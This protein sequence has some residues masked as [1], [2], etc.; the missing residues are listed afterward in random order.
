[1]SRA[2]A[3]AADLRS[4]RTGG[5]GST[6]GQAPDLTV[7]P[8]HEGS[9]VAA[10]PILLAAQLLD[11]VPVV[12]PDA[13]PAD[14]QVLARAA[15]LRRT[16]DRGEPLLVV[17]TSGTSGRPRAVVRT[18]ASWQASWAGFDTL[19]DGACA[20][21]EV[22]WVPGATASTLT[23]FGLWHALATGRPVVASGRWRGGSNA[24]A[25]AGATAVHC[26]PAV[27]ADL[28]DARAAGQLPALRRAIVA[29]AAF[30]AGLRRRAIALG[31][32]PVEYYGAAELSFV[33]ADPDGSGLRAFPGAEVSIRDGLIWVRSP[34]LARGYLDPRDGGPLRR[35]AAGWASVGDR[36]HLSADG[37]LTVRGRGD[38]TASVG[39]HTVILDDVER[40]L[41]AVDGVAEVVCLAVPD[42]RFG[43]R[44]LAAVRPAP[45]TTPSDL[46]G[47]LRAAA[48]AQLQPAARPARYMVREELPRTPGGKVAR[49]LLA[50]ELTSVDRTSHR[51]LPA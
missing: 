45:G 16:G 37:V 30:P 43:Q 18:T 12:T 33:A 13:T 42:P 14:D 46:V 27:L 38:G 24:G 9:P 28:L 40:A 5:G 41:A 21:G 3:I 17:V 35:E 2:E 19:L 39:G 10:L 23:L 6:E 44:V 51:T 49:S 50:A 47:A 34:Y 31:V 4:P 22:I 29:G 15:D 32:Q 20:P 8:V 48:R 25:V 7:V 1:L 26:V 36:G 11:A